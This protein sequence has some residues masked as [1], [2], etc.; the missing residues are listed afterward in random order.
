MTQ[1]RQS[2]ALAGKPGFETATREHFTIPQQ[3]SSPAHHN[4]RGETESAMDSASFGSI[5]DSDVGLA[6]ALKF[7]EAL[8]P[9]GNFTFQTFSESHDAKLRY[10]SGSGRNRRDQLARA[11]NGSLERHLRSLVEKNRKGAG[12]FVMVNEGDGK[13]RRQRNVARVRAVFAD[14]DGTDPTPALEATPP[15]HLVVQSSENG[16]HAYWRVNDCGLEEFKPVQ[17]QIATAFGSDPRVCD[18]P[19]VMRLPGFYHQKGT[20]FRSRLIEIL[21][22]EPYALNELAFLR[23]ASFRPLPAAG[24]GFAKLDREW[25]SSENWQSMPPRARDLF[26]IACGMFNGR[27][28]GD[29]ALTP[30]TLRGFPDWQCVQTCK[31]WRDFLTARGWLIPT[32]VGRPNLYAISVRPIQLILTPYG[33]RKHHHQPTKLAPDTWRLWTPDA[34]VSLQ[35]EIELEHA[36]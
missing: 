29:I 23:S 34:P 3:G 11:V 14:F 4:R 7:L 1:E 19:R 21:D 31:R 13:G 15:P 17:G 24:Q 30:G 10:I 22:R 28:N 20:P 27:N 2:P 12:V 6:E 25:T 5:C 18:L 32:R 33:A 36:A 26:A 35:R 8:D 16:Y 9:N